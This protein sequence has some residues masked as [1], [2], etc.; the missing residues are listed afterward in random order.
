[1]CVTGVS[2]ARTNI[3]LA[4]QTLRRRSSDLSTCP[5]LVARQLHAAARRIASGNRQNSVRNTS[6]F[7]PVP[8]ISCQGQAESHAGGARSSKLL[9]CQA[10]PE[11]WGAIRRVRSG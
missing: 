4:A 8:V 9:H 1:M 5:Q 10:F 11:R 2:A 3:V 6:L 7:P